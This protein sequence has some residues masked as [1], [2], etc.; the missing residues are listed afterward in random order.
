MNTFRVHP[1]IYP[2]FFSSILKYESSKDTDEFSAPPLYRPR[3]RIWKEAG[4]LESLR[5]LRLFIACTILMHTYTC[6]S[7]H[8][9]LSITGFYTLH[10]IFLVEPAHASLSLSPPPSFS[11]LRDL[12]SLSLSLLSRPLFTHPRFSSGCS[13]TRANARATAHTRGTH[14]FSLSSS[15]A[16][17]VKPVFED[18]SR[19]LRDFPNAARTHARVRNFRRDKKTTVR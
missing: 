11:F 15:V 13:C 2:I 7:T 10:W 18:A 9:S 4:Y 8:W 6:A 17:F 1:S 19:A 3:G 16:C 5:L 14:V 12:C